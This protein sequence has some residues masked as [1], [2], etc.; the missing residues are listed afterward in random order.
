MYMQF[1]CIYIYIYRKK[2]EGLR[3]YSPVNIIFFV[4]SHSS[5]PGSELISLHEYFFYLIESFLIAF[6]V[7][8]AKWQLLVCQESSDPFYMVSYYMK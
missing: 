5:V 3:V 4:L 7:R 6:Y 2:L 1:I 8:L